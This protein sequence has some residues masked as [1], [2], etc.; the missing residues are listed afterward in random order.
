MQ[1]FN[2]LNK[3]PNLS[4]AL[5][6]F[7]GVHIG[8]QEV[9]KSAV[10]FA[11]KNNTKSAIITF[12]KHPNKFLFGESPKYILTRKERENKIKN[13]GIDYLYELDFE[14]IANLDAQTY[15]KEVLIE[16]FS[17]I[18]ISTGWNHHFGYKKSGDV[19]FLRKNSKLYNY[20]YFEIEPK[21]FNEEIVSSSLIR[22]LLTFAEIEKVNNLL[23][24]NFYINE[25]VI[26]GNKL[27]RTLG[28]RTANIIYPQNIVEI[29]HGVYSVN[30]ELPNK[31]IKK[32]IANFGTRPTINDS[33]TVLEVHILDFDQDIYGKKLSIRFNKKIRDEKKFNNLDELKNQIQKDILNI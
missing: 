23:G 28:F 16:N 21:M 8:H 26:E 5:G 29:P 31:I 15:L 27:G 1:I 18:S 10:N 30:I 9:I 7:D 6:F 4:L 12:K 20:Q 32:G 14:N 13:L 3:N 25:K 33:N 22:R 19:E 2:S 24:Y 17:P 11:K